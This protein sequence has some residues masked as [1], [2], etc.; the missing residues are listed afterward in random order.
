MGN[1]PVDGEDLIVDDDVDVEGFAFDLGLQPGTPGR[2]VLG[3]AKLPPDPVK[4]ASAASRGG[5]DGNSNEPLLH[6]EADDDADEVDVEG[7]GFSIGGV[8]RP[9][10]PPIRGVLDGIALPEP[11]AGLNQKPFGDPLGRAGAA[12]NANEPLVHDGDG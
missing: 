4:P 2:P 12:P 1:G 9:D 8:L 3:A 11:G 7:F 6:D 5:W 10:G